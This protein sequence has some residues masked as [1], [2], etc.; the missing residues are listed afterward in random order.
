MEEERKRGTT[1]GRIS[2]VLLPIYSTTTWTKLWVSWAYELRIWF[3]KIQDKAETEGYVMSW[4]AHANFSLA[5]IYIYIYS[6]E[7]KIQVARIFINNCEIW[8]VT[9]WS[10]NY[11]KLARFSLLNVKHNF[12]MMFCC[13]ISMI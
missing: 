8:S 5:Y 9:V 2:K 6:M 13:N 10:Y 1:F 12:K 4:W 3:R 11:V 7:Q